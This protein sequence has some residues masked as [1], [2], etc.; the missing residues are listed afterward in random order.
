MQEE[1]KVPS[2]LSAIIGCK[3]PRC[4]T[5]NMF[6]Y[7]SLMPGKF[8]KMNH[9]CP[10]CGAHFE[11]EPGFYIGAMYV[12]YGFG[13]AIVGAMFIFFNVYWEEAPLSIYMGS[14]VAALI[15]AVPVSYRYARVLYLHWFGGLVFD[16]KYLK[17]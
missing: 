15:L 5:G 2:G 7:N 17:K 16:R 12:S 13:V 3:C 1:Q 8:A 10:N 9:D 4:R 6:V 11:P 14:V